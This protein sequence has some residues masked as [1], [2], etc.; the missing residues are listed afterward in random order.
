MLGHDHVS[1]N[2]EPIPLPRPLQSL[3]ED[4]TRSRCAQTRSALIAAKR[5]RVQT[6]RFLKSLETP[7]HRLNRKPT[8]GTPICDREIISFLLRG[9]GNVERKSTPPPCLC[10]P[11]RDKDGHPIFDFDVILKLKTRSDP[12]G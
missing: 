10:Q 7:R 5:Q 3:L 1:R 4:V 8:S 11:R 6:A 2:V 12:S 9:M